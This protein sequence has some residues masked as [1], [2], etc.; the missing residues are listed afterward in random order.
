MNAYKFLKLLMYAIPSLIT[1]GVAYY[2]FQSHFKDQ[3]NTRKW[4]LLREKQKHSLPIK[5]QA[6]HRLP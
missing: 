1:G 6:N 5:L 4:V 2:M 3:Q